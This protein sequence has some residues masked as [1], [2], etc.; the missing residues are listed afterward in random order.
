MV[1]FLMEDSI[2]F[3]I[4]DSL[5]SLVSFIEAAADN[6]VAVHSTDVVDVSRSAKAQETFRFPLFVVDLEIAGGPQASQPAAA[7]PGAN[8]AAPGTDTTP[9]DDTIV[10]GTEPSHFKEKILLLIDKSLCSFE[11]IPTIERTVMK[12][13][14]WSSIPTLGVVSKTESA[15][16]DILARLHCAFQKALV[17]L[18]QYLATYSKYQPLLAQ[19]T[20]Q[21]LADF[22]TRL[23]DPPPANPLSELVAEITKQLMLRD[24]VENSIPG[25]ISVGMF[26]VNCS[27]VKRV[28]SDKRKSFAQAIL[29]MLCQMTATATQTIFKE[30]DQILHK[31]EEKPPNIEAL[32]D[33]KQYMTTIPILLKQLQRKID[34]V[35]VYYDTLESFNYNLQQDQFNNRWLVM[36]WPQRITEKVEE[37]TLYQEKDKITFFKQ[38]TEAKQ[39]FDEKLENLKKNVSA[40]SRSSDISQHEIMSSQVKAV[41]QQLK[42][43]QDTVKVF[44]RRERLFGIELSPFTDVTALVKAFD[45]FH[46]LWTTASEWIS[47]Y[48]SWMK[49]TFASLNAA[50]ME[51]QLN[52]GTIMMVK[53]GESFKNTPACLSIVTNIRHQ[54]ETFQP[55]MPLIT[56][57]RN[58]GMRPRHWEKLRKDMEFNVE[59]GDN[60]LTLQTLLQLGLEASLQIIQQVTELAGKEY[61]IEAALTKMEKEWEDV[62]FDVRPYRNTG[63]YVIRGTDDINQQLDDHLVMTQ[64]MAFSIYKKPFEERIQQWEAKL[65]NVLACV[66]E[67]LACQRQ[68]LYL[69]P[70]FSSEDI[71]RQLPAEAKRYATVDIMWRRLMNSAK[72]TPQVLSIANKKTLNDLVECHKLFELIH[73]GL[74]EYL[75][76]KQAAFPRFYFLSKKELLEILSQTKDPTAVQPHLHKCFENISSLEFAEDKKILSMN[77][78]EHE[79]VDFITP[80]YPT[81]HVENWLLEVESQMKLSV[82]KVVSDAIAAY[83]QHKRTEWVQSWPGQAVLVGCSL[84]WTRAVTK[85]IQQGEG[86]KQLLQELLGQLAD[87]TTLVRGEL[88][89]LVRLTL[90]SLIVMDIHQRD[91]VLKLLATGIE[92]EKAFEWI[93]QLRYYWDNDDLTACMVN[94][95]FKYGYEYLGNTSRLV[96]TPLTDNCYMTLT[97]ALHLQLGGAPQGPAGTGKTETTKDLAKA[98]AKQC[99][100]FNCS[101]QLNFQSM[102]KFFKG[103]A[104]SGAWACLDEFNT[105]KPEVLSVVAQQ[106]LSIQRAIQVNAKQLTMAGTVIPVNPTCAVFITMNPGYAGRSELPDNLKARFRPVAM[107]VPDYAMIAEIMLVSFGF[108]DAKSLA[109]KMIA[110]FRLSSEQLSSQDHYDFGMRAVKTVISAAGNLKKDFPDMSESI[111]LLRALRDCNGPKFLAVDIPLFEG[112][113]SDLFPNVKSPVVDYGSLMEGLKKAATDMKLQPVPQ[114]LAKCIQLYETTLVRH[115]LMLVGPTGGGKTSSIRVLASAMTILHKQGNPNFQQVKYTVIN[116][117]SLTMGQLYGEMHKTTHEWNEGVLAYVVREDAQDPS[118]VKKWCIFDGPVDAIWV[119][120][121]NTVLDDNKKLCLTSGEIITLSPTQTIMFEVEDLAVASPATV[122]RCGMIYMEPAD[123]GVAP[124]ITSGLQAL[125]LEIHTE[126]GPRVQSLFDAYLQPS[127]QCVRR[128][129]PPEIVLTTNGNLTQSLLNLLSAMLTPW[130]P[131]SDEIDAG[132]LNSPDGQPVGKLDT[133]LRPIFFFCLVWSVGATTD[134]Q[135]RTKFDMFLRTLMDT[136]KEECKFPIGNTCYDYQYSIPEAKWVPWVNLINSSALNVKPTLANF[137]HII[138]PTVDTMRY[139]FLLDVLLKSGKQVLCIGGTGTGKSVIVKDKLLNGMTERHQTVILNFSAQTSANATKEIIESKLDKR[140][141]GVWGPPAGNKLVVFIDDVNMPKKEFYG[142]QPPLELMRQWLDHGIWYDRKAL[143]AGNAP[144]E[145]IVDMLLVGAMGPPGGGRTQISPRFTRHFN[146]IQF[147]QLQRDTLRHIFKSILVPFLQAFPE[148][149]RQTADSVVMATVEVYSTCCLELLPTPAKSHYTFNLRDL[150]KV[151]QGLLCSHPS[152]IHTAVDFLRLWCHECCRVFQDRLVDMHDRVWFNGIIKSVLQRN[153]AYTFEDVTGVLEKG[154]MPRLIFGDFMERSID[155]DSRIYCEISE[156]DKLVQTINEALDFYNNTS[157]TPMKLIMFLD[158]IE[159]VARVSRTIRQPQGNALLL[160][161][162]GS[163]R[164]SATYLACSMSGYDIFRVEIS[165]EYSTTEWHDDVKK[166]LSIAGLEGKPIVFVFDDTQIIDELFLEDVNNILNSGEVP[167]V[168]QPEELTN[169]YNTIR[170][171]CENERLSVTKEGIY[172]HFLQ[173]IRS[174]L[175][176]VLCMSPIGDAFRDRLR[177]FPSL[178]NCCTIDWFSGWPDDALHSLAKNA[179]TKLGFEE[180]LS[181]NLSKLCVVIF[182]SVERASTDYKQEQNRTNWVTPTSYLEL[183]KVFKKILALKKQELTKTRQRMQ[184]G[185][186]KIQQASRDVA[187]LQAEQRAAQPLLEQA[188]IETNNMMAKIEEDQKS[189]DET[190]NRVKLDEAEAEKKTEETRVMNDEAQKELQEVLPALKSAEMALNS[191]NRNDIVEVRS[192]FRPP[193]GVKMVMEAI[194]IV[195]GVKPVKKADSSGKGKDQFD[196]WEPAKLM[197]NDPNFLNSL[198]TYDVNNIPEAVIQKLQPYIL[199]DDFRP[200]AIAKVS[201]ACTSLC[202]WV[203]AIENYFHV[204]KA[205]APK[206]A[207]VTQCEEA[208]AEM[209]RKLNE[210]KQHLA[211]VEA[212]IQGLQRAYDAKLDEKRLL[213]KKVQD[214][215]VKLDR[216]QTLLGALEQEHARWQDTLKEVAVQL[217]NLVGDAILSASTIAFIGVFTS[218]Y[219]NRLLTEWQ[220]MLSEY[221]IA[222]TRNCTIR[223][224]RGDPFK[225]R[226]WIADGLP[227]NA[228]S[229]ENALIITNSRRWPLMIDPQGQANKWIKKFEKDHLEVIKPN[230]D[231]FLRTLENAIRFGQ[232]VLLENVGESLDPVLDPILM[233]QTFKQDGNVVIKFGSQTVPYH[234]DFKLY[235]TTKLPNPTYKPEVSTKVT[236]INFTITPEGLADQLLGLVVSKEKPKLEEDKN[237]LVIMNNRMKADIKL[238]EDKMLCLMSESAGNPLE[239]LSLIHTL[240]ESKKASEEIKQKMIE[241]AENER[242]IDLTRQQYQ[243]IAL[244]AS[245]LFFCVTDLSLI[246]PMYQFSLKWFIDL[247]SASIKNSEPSDDLPTRLNNLHSHFTY[248]L[249]CNVCRS[250]FVAHKQLFSFQLCARVLQSANEIV[251]EQWRF[252]LTGGIFSADKTKVAENPA[253]GWLE[254]KTWNDI[255]CLSQIHPF[256]DLAQSVGENLAHFKSYFDSADPLNYLLPKQWNKALSDFEKMLVLRCFRPDAMISA[257]QDF[258]SKK[259]GAKFVEPPEFDLHGAFNDSARDVFLIFVLSPG[260]DPQADLNRFA[261]EKRFSRKLDSISLGQGQGP[262]AEAMIQEAMEKGLWVLLQN[263]HLATSWMPTLEKILEGMNL[264]KCHKDFRLWLTSMPTS[265]FPISV[266]QNSVKMTNEPPK[267][268]KANMLRTYAQFDDNFLTS[269]GDKTNQWKKMLFGLCFFHA[270]ILERRKFGPL[271]WNIPYEFTNGDLNICVRQLKMF[272]AEY[273]EIPYKV[274]CFLAG[275]IN[276]GGRIT[277]MWD[278]RTLSTLLSGAYCPAV[279]DDDFS[280]SQSGLYKSPPPFTAK[281]YMTFLRQLPLNDHPE[282]FGLHDNADIT[283]HLSTVQAIFS[284]MQLLES[285]SASAGSSSASR[286]QMIQSFT[287]EIQATLPAQ[288]KLAES[289]VC[290][291]KE[292]MTTVLSQEIIR[293]NRL[294]NVIHTSLKELQMALKGLVVMSKAL[295]NMAACIYDNQVPT[296]WAEKAYPSLMPLRAW[297]TDLSMRLNFLMKWI[298]TGIPLVFWISGFFSPQAFLT[299]TLQNFARKKTIPIDTVAFDYEVLKETEDQ[300][301]SRPDDGCY[302]KGLFLEGARFNRETHVVDESLPKKLYDSLPIIWLRPI[303]GKEPRPGSYR[304]PV[305]KILTRAGTLSTTG[306]STNYVMTIELPSSHD[307]GHWIKRG[308][309]AV[310]SLTYASSTQ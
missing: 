208:L 130:F 165:N 59:V 23:G 34:N 2:R 108:S 261:E 24:E 133:H 282:V 231:D 280:F 62:K 308:V 136:N 179:F 100:V 131:Q 71:N 51:Q 42:E 225:E 35:I 55:H 272:I 193:N 109:Q 211:D 30:F 80:F 278:M 198:L 124:L 89:S 54:M 96:I 95:S 52:E 253:P 262:R 138:I 110:T 266:L 158:A 263:C 10:L 48:D 216:A 274:M 1:R 177:M 39:T 46:N 6:L 77:S 279:L 218:T 47:S 19:K 252:M 123:L 53:L 191:L 115:G 103:I 12:N 87:L 83:P 243:G 159:H 73:S 152:T 21:Y 203:R 114:F 299:G 237:N 60:S 285:S 205:I 213:E 186:D 271:G 67:W 32:M 175:H 214:C 256:T 302:I 244:H 288:I 112:I 116:P 61:V 222:H 97:S 86:L 245:T 183:L 78:A 260:A 277:D 180:A 8:G 242:N 226:Q 286:E 254:A 18:E 146:I 153:T 160:G 189:A 64:T 169:I 270:T 107:M 137:A 240:A 235:I 139:T 117:K 195:K 307:E 74:T 65:R 246:D 241:S 264:E 4:E 181:L 239:D 105:I 199:S 232:S 304:C 156:M 44:N 178:V 190:R 132:F 111:I 150:A 37:V 219:R 275:T 33:T 90:G 210:T 247:F 76:T 192:M 220:S 182:R 72:G 292:S 289:I 125:P 155:V 50:A 93:S 293:Y 281:E 306:H 9:A 273:E 66:D 102:A 69:E 167:N 13:L 250:L 295:E 142:A 296:L 287:T 106:I 185:I 56:A 230:Q 301:K 233:K 88:T 43:C 85:A 17:P 58:P 63:T 238:I 202:I 57:L 68:W 163:G 297:V 119:E 207:R 98:F 298:D 31:L 170:P 194:C 36:R 94:A 217:N 135:G 151:F 84:Y 310:C 134:H 234:D 255:I 224:T 81:A 28:L 99:V 101:D 171:I 174:N 5:E 267:G 300:I 27:E 147:T 92:N 269:C 227:D 22:H 129:L 120:K 309:A 196:Y 75:A 126:F 265:K 229:I 248:S 144:F 29:D 141:K 25:V 184:S 49:S 176:V 91:V 283:Y 140:R 20:E 157:K 204:E 166:M 70:I 268:I 257:I 291:P 212:S 201:R 11:N 14:F 168:W 162:G 118:P 45:P 206:R 121:L 188:T 200:F 249:Y 197:L 258:I 148:P 215:Q 7:A 228:I 209:N 104:S 154:S 128:D 16:V 26:L 290:D 38:F 164:K 236:L 161:I 294:L 221:E 276:Y 149:V 113:L 223:S 251:P 305:Y 41:R 143:Q 303:T 127:L 284:S 82:H 79:K 3:L 15:V 259:L 172:N 40:I 122:S 187:V 173:I 145:E